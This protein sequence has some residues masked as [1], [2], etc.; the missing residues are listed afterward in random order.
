MSDSYLVF[1]HMLYFKVQSYIHQLSYLALVLY[2]SS[3]IVLNNKGV[4][5]NVNEYRN[6]SSTSEEIISQIQSVSAEDSPPPPYKNSACIT[7]EIL[8][9]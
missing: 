9:P 4:N 3:S 8:I 2:F 7:L 6:L 5:S 1:Q